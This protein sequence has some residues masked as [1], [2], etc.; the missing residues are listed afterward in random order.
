MAWRDHKRQIQQQVA[1]ILDIPRDLI[2]DLPKLTVV[3][4]LQISIENHR[5]IVV[6]TSEQVRINTTIGELE[7]T[8][9]DLTLRNILPD[10]IMLE[11]KIRSVTFKG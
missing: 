6:Y 4:D 11:G 9:N 2:M 10:E 3:G 1:S 5:G 7:V 8:G